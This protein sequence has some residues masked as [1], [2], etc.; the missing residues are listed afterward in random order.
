VGTF[1]FA[2]CEVLG[3]LVEKGG[4]GLCCGVDL[5]PFTGVGGEGV[6]VQDVVDSE[7]FEVWVGGED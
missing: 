4:E 7:G 5:A 2:C 6:G 1:L 3:G